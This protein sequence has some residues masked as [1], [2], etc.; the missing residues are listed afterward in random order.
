MNIPAMSDQVSVQW[1]VGVQS[2]AQAAAKAEGEAAVAL[3]KQSKPEP[4]L[5]GQGTHINTYA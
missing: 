3:I 5:E 1:G 4:G 2:K